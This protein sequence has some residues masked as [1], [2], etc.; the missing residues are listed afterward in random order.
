MNKILLIAIC[1]YLTID[2]GIDFCATLINYKGKWTNIFDLFWDA[3]K[4]CALGYVFSLLS[5]LV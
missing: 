4:I 2:A 3:G 5:D 1:M